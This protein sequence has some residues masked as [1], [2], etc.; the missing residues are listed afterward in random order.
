MRIGPS[1][2]AGS[3]SLLTAATFFKMR[4]IYFGDRI[5]DAEYNGKLYGLG[6][7]A[8]TLANGVG[9]ENGTGASTPGGGGNGSLSVSSTMSGLAGSAYGGGAFGTGYAGAFGSGYGLGGAAMTAYGMRGGSGATIAERE[10]TPLP[11]SAGGGQAQ[12][13]ASQQGSQQA[14]T[15]QGGQQQGS[16]HTSG[17]FSMGSPYGS[18]SVTNGPYIRQ[19]NVGGER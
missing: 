4:E 7:T 15:P 14:G 1:H 9:G 6:P 10:R 19:I 12:G 2:Q 17:L 5:D 11:A 18:I 3:D 16:V 13:Q 8:A